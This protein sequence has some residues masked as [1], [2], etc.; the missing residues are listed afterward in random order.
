MTHS[1]DPIATDIDAFRAYIERNGIR[2]RL[3]RDGE[4]EEEADQFVRTL[5]RDRLLKFNVPELV[6]F[7]RA[8]RIL[9]T[10]LKADVLDAIS[11]MVTL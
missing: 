5:L 2:E 6:A 1:T 9:A 8:N 10:G 4:T 3:I 7:A 11:E